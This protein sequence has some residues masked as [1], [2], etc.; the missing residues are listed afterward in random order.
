[1]ASDKTRKLTHT[2]KAYRELKKPFTSILTYIKQPS[3]R[4]KT[5]EA[6]YPNPWRNVLSVLKGTSHIIFWTS[7]LAPFAASRVACSLKD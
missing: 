7:A 4:E 1:M 2:I 5:P 6:V 3:L